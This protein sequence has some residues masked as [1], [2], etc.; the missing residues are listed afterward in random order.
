M[1]LL[2]L[3]EIARELKIPESTIRYRARL[4]DEFL[5]YVQKGRR[6]LY[7][8]EAIEVFK[9]VAECLRKGLDRN[10]TATE[11][12]RLFPSAGEASEIGGV[13]ATTTQQQRNNQALPAVL[14]HFAEAENALIE[15]LR[16]QQE[17]NRKLE[18]RIRRLEESKGFWE[19]LLDRIL[20][21]RS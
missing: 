21:R 10:A 14:R 5:P 3:A 11:L 7:R 17:I 15:I 20:G 16:E 18:E 19:R 6:K 8:R 2:T 4:F 12:M 9:V 1:E 13:P